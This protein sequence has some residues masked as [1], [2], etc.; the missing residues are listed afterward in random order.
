MKPAHFD[1]TLASSIDEAIQCLADGD[2]EAIIL[3]GGQTLMPMLSMRLARPDMVI[4]INEIPELAG[5]EARDGEIVIKACTRQAAALSSPIVNEHLPLLAKAIGNVGHLQTR[6]RGTVGGSL[7]HADPAAEIPLAALVLDAQ[8]ELRNVG[9][10]RQLTMA[11][12]FVGPMMTARESDELLVSLRFPTVGVPARV[13]TSFH[14]V[15]ERHGDFAI[16]AVAARITLGGDGT[17]QQAA[18]A[19]GGVDACPLRIDGLESVLT[20][21]NINAKIL[22]TAVDLIDDAI[23]PSSDQHASADYRRRVARKLAERA[24]MEALADAKRDLG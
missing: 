24:I 20:G 9:G 5:I 22:A 15:S 3:A 19:F 4:D 1:Y 23:E 17:C 2:G 10:R 12:Y 8:V 14:E 7:A 13:G 11:D 16:V 18:V 21:Q 6:N